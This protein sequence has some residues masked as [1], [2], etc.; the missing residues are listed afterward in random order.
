GV[1][2]GRLSAE[3]AEIGAV[4]FVHTAGVAGSIPAAPTISRRCY[5]VILSA[6]L[7]GPGS[8]TAAQ[9]LR[10]ALGAAAPISSMISA[11]AVCAASS[12]RC[13]ARCTAAIRDHSAGEALAIV[14]RRLSR[15]L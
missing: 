8:E 10:I 3:T 5:P 6:P 13:A 9:F 12:Q 11:I 4:V 1:K 2:S 14:A 7:E 15:F